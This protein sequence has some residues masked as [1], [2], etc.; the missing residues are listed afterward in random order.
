MKKRKYFE[1]PQKI[2]DIDI[3]KTLT[4][5]NENGIIYHII[6]LITEHLLVANC[7]CRFITKDKDINI[8][9]I[10][11][12]YIII[13]MGIKIE[14]ADHICSYCSYFYDCSFPKRN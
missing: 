5:L 9:L 14:Q 8:G 7:D 13:E 11:L 12:L 3:V 2:D 10:V 1:G 6:D 4:V